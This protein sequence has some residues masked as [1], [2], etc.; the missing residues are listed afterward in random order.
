MKN[1]RQVI[2][3]NHNFVTGE[4]YEQRVLKPVQASHNRVTIQL[5]DA[6]SGKVIEEAVTENAITPFLESSAYGSIANA[7]NDSNSNGTLNGACSYPA[8]SSIVLSDSDIGELED[9][10]FIHG[11]VVGMCNRSDTAG[12][13]DSKYRGTYNSAESYQTIEDNGYKHIHLVYD[14]PTSSG[15]GKI[16]NIYWMPVA[17]YNFDTKG[18]SGCPRF[19]GTLQSFNGNYKKFSDLTFDKRG[20]A[21]QVRDHKYYKVLN[22]LK[23]INGIETLKTETDESFHNN[24]EVNGCYYTFSSSYANSGK[25]NFSMTLTIN[26]HDTTGAILD[27]W[28]EDLITNVPQLVELRNNSKLG[29]SGSST[30]PSASALSYCDDDGWVGIQVNYCAYNYTYVFPTRNNQGELEPNKAYYVTVYSMYNVLTKQWLHV[31]NPWDTWC[32]YRHWTGYD[33]LKKIDSRHLCRDGY[34]VSIDVNKADVYGEAYSSSWCSSIG[35]ST[36]N[37]DYDDY[38]YPIKFH[39]SLPIAR[40]YYNDYYILAVRPISA[41]T[42][43]AAP[44]TKTTLNTMKIQ[45]DFFFKIPLPYMPPEHVWD[46]YK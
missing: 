2:K 12:A 3:T 37:D 13:G 40:G 34:L 46:L 6:S 15:N 5:C 4:H 33:V 8:F 24:Y 14:W 38:G 42:R 17:I 10:Y 31:P 21:Y 36:E 25:S 41:Q 30:K 43:L 44:I 22:L 27:T 39:A 11:N 16:Q 9:L 18:S 23:A 19:V 45:Y 26:K 7:L 1:M 28:N 29:T 32:T 20:N 35:K